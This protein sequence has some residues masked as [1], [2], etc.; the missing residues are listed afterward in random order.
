MSESAA[1]LLRLLLILAILAAIAIF[2]RGGLDL[3]RAP[4]Q[5]QLTAV[6]G[7]NHALKASADAQTAGV[8]GLKTDSDART[9]KSKV[10]IAAAGKQEERRATEI[11]EAPPIGDSDYE[12]AINRID[13]ELG[14]K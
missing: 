13:R 3:I 8:K 7:D 5:A 12:R 9:A 1:A 10:A 2:A 11:L 4:V 14:L 6:I